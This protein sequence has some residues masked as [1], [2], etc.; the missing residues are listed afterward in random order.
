MLDSLA[1]TVSERP[2]I[3]GFFRLDIA[4]GRAPETERFPARQSAGKHLVLPAP[5]SVLSWPEIGFCPADSG[6]GQSAECVAVTPCDRGSKS[7]LATLE[8]VSETA[9]V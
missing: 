1:E 4:L 3:A 7:V 5:E 8:S 2:G 9:L 6:S